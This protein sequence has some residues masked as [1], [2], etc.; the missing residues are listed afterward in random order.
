[1]PTGLT[2]AAT[3]WSTAAVGMA[4]G[5]GMYLLSPALAILILLILFSH[6]LPGFKEW[7]RST[8]AQDDD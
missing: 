7:G 3:L 6:H 2:T 5:F 1:M 4:A 8:E